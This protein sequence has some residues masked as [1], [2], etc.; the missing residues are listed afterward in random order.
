LL[1][2]HVFVDLLHVFSPFRYL[3]LTNVESALLFG[4]RLGLD[5]T[6]ENVAGFIAIAVVYDNGLR[7]FHFKTFPELLIVGVVIGG[8]I[9]GVLGDG[10]GGV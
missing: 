5:R 1:C 10:V 6:V 9:G 3:F 8:V 4:L 7:L 2:D